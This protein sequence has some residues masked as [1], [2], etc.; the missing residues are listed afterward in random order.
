M[1][2][3]FGYRKYSIV[4]GMLLDLSLPSFNTVICN[5]RT[6]FNLCAANVMNRVIQAVTVL[7]SV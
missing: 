2:S 5:A 3:F 7:I 6:K 4:T 1:K